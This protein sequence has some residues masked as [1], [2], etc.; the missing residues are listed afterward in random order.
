LKTKNLFIKCSCCGICI[1]PEYSTREYKELGQYY[2]CPAC[3]TS[4]EKDNFLY[5]EETPKHFHYVLFKDGLIKKL[6]LEE[7][8]KLQKH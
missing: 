1:G 8:Q 5:I 7:L 6:R 3:N 4:L 2:L